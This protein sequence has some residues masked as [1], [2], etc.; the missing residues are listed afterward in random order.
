M[1]PFPRNDFEPLASTSLRL[2]LNY[3]FLTHFSTLRRTVISVL[4]VVCVV[5]YGWSIWGAIPILRDPYL[6]S[7]I[8][9]EVAAMRIFVPTPPQQLELGDVASI[10]TPGSTQ[11]L[12]TITN[13]NDDRV[14]VSVNYEFRQ[15][16]GTAVASGWT[17]LL[18]GETRYAAGVAT[19][20]AEDAELVITGT[21]W[22]RQMESDPIP[23]L[24]LVARDVTLE[25][26]SGQPSRATFVAVN[27]DLV[28]YRSV[29]AVAVARSNGT[30]VAVGTLAIS[31][32]AV[33]EERPSAV[34]W[35][36]P[37]PLG[38][39]VEVQLVTDPFDYANVLLPA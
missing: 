33:G 22:E 30:I 36:H 1:S 12:A 20:E 17:W 29:T 8:A 26:E 14:A 39:Q 13:P 27:N 11:L 5:L 9:D 38:S 10:V 6:V 37:V 19:G 25:Y 24:Q 15:P 16:G 35:Y 31:N 34:T 23:A 28:G 7:R 3:W 2:R 18:P 4:A 32:L 21:D